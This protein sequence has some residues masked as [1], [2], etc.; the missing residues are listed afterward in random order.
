MTINIRRIRADEWQRLR[1]LRL[2]AL[3]DAPMAFGSTIAQ[4]EA[5]S[6]S[7]WRERAAGGADG[8]DRV[9]FIAERDEQ[10]VGLAT[11]LLP[12]TAETAAAVPTL[13]GMFVDGSVRRQGVGVALV[14]EIAQWAG[15]RRA[16]RLALWVTEGNER[17]LAL[18]RRC[19]FRRT[20]VTR[21]HSHAPG[22]T[23]C[24][25]IRVPG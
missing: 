17:A 8:V 20:G 14:E 10:W 19:G 1:E 24:E 16:T 11:C 15:S 18:Y 23:E 6:D 5:Y 21:P 9:T 12:G 7:V 22:H 25:M 3:A 13:V 2:R 4:E